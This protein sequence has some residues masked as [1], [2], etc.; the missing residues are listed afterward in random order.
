MRKRRELCKTIQE[1]YTKGTKGLLQSAHHLIYG[2]YR[3]TLFAAKQGQQ[4]DWIYSIQQAQEDFQSGFVWR[5]VSPQHRNLLLD[6]LS[7][8]AN[9]TLTA[10]PTR[11]QIA[12]TIP[13]VSGRRY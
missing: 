9:S 6:W 8:N 3:K 12:S 11:I 4:R 7:S 5:P 10:L 2:Y 1:E 13:I